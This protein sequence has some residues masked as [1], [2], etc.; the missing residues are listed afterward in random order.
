MFSPQVFPY[1]GPA[2]DQEEIESLIG[3][4]NQLIRHERIYKEAAD[5]VF[6]RLLA[7]CPVEPGIHCAEIETVDDGA[8]RTI[9]LVVY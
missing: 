6:R 5:V 8:E 9:K 1:S 7:G 3:L 2:I 4:R